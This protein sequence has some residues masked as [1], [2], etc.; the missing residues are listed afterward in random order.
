LS[1]TEI[2]DIQAE[3]LKVINE[4]INQELSIETKRKLVKILQQ[5]I[6]S[7]EEKLM[8][9]SDSELTSLLNSV[10]KDESQKVNSR[11][12]AVESLFLY[13]RIQ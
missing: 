10:A 9:S 3:V 5:Q 6:C 12:G 4:A 11:K 2:A 1:S 13:S 7:F 8:R